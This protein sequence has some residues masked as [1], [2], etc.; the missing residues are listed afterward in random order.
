M[1][2]TVL[3]RW[4]YALLFVALSAGTLGAQVL[5]FLGPDTEQETTEEPEAA[6]TQAEDSPSENKFESQLAAYEAWANDYGALFSERL[7]TKRFL[8][9]DYQWISCF[10]LVFLG[11][12]VDFAIRFLLSWI[13]RFVRKDSDEGDTES[14]KQAER[15]V[16]KPI[17]LLAQASTW[18]FGSFLIGF[19]IS[20]LRVLAVGLKLFAVFAAVWTA[21]RVIDWLAGVISRKALGTATKF[22]D[23][24]VPLIQKCLKAFVVC[25]GIVFF[26]DV[27]DLEV[28]ALI[29]GLG[30]G[31]AALAFASQD[32]LSNLFGSL[33]VLADRPFEIG[34][35]IVSDGVEGTVENVGMRST[36]VRTFYNSVI[37]LP[38]SRLTTSIVDNMGRREFRRFTTT[39]G[40]QYDTTPEQIDAF[41]EGIREI[42]RR[43]PYTRKDYFQVYLNAFSNSSVDILLYM[44]FQCGDWPTELRER[45]RLLIDV[46]K[47]AAELD[48]QFAFPTQTLHMFREENNV[49]YPSLHYQNPDEHGRSAAVSVAGEHMTQADYPP[50]VSVSAKLGAAEMGE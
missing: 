42:I 34:D 44:F 47:L 11:L 39:I 27:F 9:K 7:H 32:T 6:D 36:R 19:P 40:V 3:S 4:S 48:V 23:I 41:C 12:F 26:A 20:V 2:S 22:D 17:G 5:P 37:T 25:T 24:L 31:G 15:K 33:T 46:M 43:H 16:W 35:W 13:V 14:D 28:T 30:L 49:D 29:G 45:H 1:M 8:L 50:V 18:Y 38:N 21:F 10:V